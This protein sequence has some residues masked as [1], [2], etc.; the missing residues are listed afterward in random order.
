[1][2]AAVLE[3]DTCIVGGGLVG[4]S[5]ALALASIDQKV[6]IIEAHPPGQPGQPSFDD[7]ATALSNGSRRVFE[8]LG[9]WPMLDEYATPIR[10]IHV[11]D[12]GRFGMSRIDASAEGVAA[13]GFM[14]RNRHIGTAL[15]TRMAQ[16]DGIRMFTPAR[17]SELSFTDAQA[18]LRVRQD[19]DPGSELVV[20]SPLAVAADG[21]RS[22]V[23]QRLGIE[24]E[25]RDYRQ[26]AI[27]ANI[28]TERD[29]CG[30][31]YERFTESGPLAVLP[32]SDEDAPGQGGRATIVWSLGADE[33][34]AISELDSDAFIE[35]LQSQFGFRLGHILRVG[36]RVSYPL[37]LVQSREQVRHRLVVAG[38]AAHSLHPVAGQGFN[39]SL[40]DVA[41]LAETVADARLRGEDAGSLEVL[42]RY[43]DWRARD[44]RDVIRFSD[45]LIKVFGSRNPFTRIGRNLGLVALELLPGAKTLLARQTMGVAGRL[46]KLARGLSLS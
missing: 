7:R 14:V 39:L 6:A 8:A 30:V 41:A 42:Q 12:Q 32:M 35:R 43:A 3:F 36:K 21:A 40:R 4:A 5:L 20:A 1:M 31:A 28:R 44:Q 26:L 25:S 16:V 18:I 15:M 33:A 19:D 22:S 10:S 9:V 11:S 34:P 29:L 45:G 27:I 2:S 17:V 24:A 37:A 23:R 13:L 46:P 38:N